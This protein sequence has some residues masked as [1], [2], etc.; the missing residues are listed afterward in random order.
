[1]LAN[2]LR[3]FVFL[4]HSYFSFF[5]VALYEPSRSDQVYTSTQHSVSSASKATDHVTI[6]YSLNT[7]VSSQGCQLN[8]SLDVFQKDTL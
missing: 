5:V 3:F 4:H 8:N 1:M 2:N 7:C 6:T